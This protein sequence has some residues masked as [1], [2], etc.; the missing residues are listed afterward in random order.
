MVRTEERSAGARSAIALVAALAWSAGVH[1]QELPGGP[2]TAS[3]SAQSPAHRL[4]DPS[5]SPPGAAAGAGQAGAATASPADP[6]ASPAP[7][8]AAGGLRMLVIDAA[9]FGIHPVVGQVTTEQMRQTAAAAGYR[10]LDHTATVNAARQLRMP[11]PPTPADLWRVSWVARSHRGAFARVW[12]RGGRYVIEIMVASLDGAGPFFAR[13]TS[14]ADDLRPVVDRLFRSAMPPPTSWVNQPATAEREAERAPEAAFEPT[15][16]RRA[17][18]AEAEARE[19]R[20][21]SLTVQTE[22]VFGVTND[23]FY[24]HLAGLRFDV[25]LNRDI[26]LGAYIAYANLNARDGRADNL[27]FMGVFEDRIRL[28]SGLD[29]TVPLRAALGY[30]PYNGAVIR[31]SAG[32]NYA[33]TPNWEIGA[34]LL[35]PNFWFLPDRT[36]IS[37]NAALETTYRF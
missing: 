35:V 6:A 4:G 25:R 34:D 12:A 5:I 33:L 28:G 22:G 19:L 18:R 29:L 1:A 31:L 24:N 13:G 30:L 37:I 11:Y 32:L 16:R 9:T 21:F 7:T 15:T 2:A 10:V 27:L 26:A 20:R 8:A 23:F 36:A 3:H 14:G 17:R